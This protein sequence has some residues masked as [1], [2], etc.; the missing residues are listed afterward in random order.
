M[1]ARRPGVDN[2]R[3][4]DEE[5]RDAL[6]GLHAYDDGATDSGIR[7]ERLR[8]R[9]VAALRAHRDQGDDHW[10]EWLARLVRDMWLSDEAISQGYGL[11]DAIEFTQWLGERMGARAA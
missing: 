11:Q 7:D 9:C 3:V 1:T 4:T 2:G 8:G 5:L 10:R 6:D